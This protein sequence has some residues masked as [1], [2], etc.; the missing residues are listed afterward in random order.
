MIVPRTRE[1][2][3]GHDGTVDKKGAGADHRASARIVTLIAAGCSNE[4]VGVRLGIS[5]RTAKAHSDVLRQK[6]GVRRR[7]QI[8]IAYRLLTGEDPL[9]AERAADGR[10]TPPLI[11]CAR[12]DS[13]CRGRTDLGPAVLG[14]MRE[15]SHSGQLWQVPRQ[16]ALCSAAG[17]SSGRGSWRFS[18]NRR[19]ASGRSWLRRLREDD[20]GRAMGRYRRPPPGVVHRTPL[21]DGCRGAG[22]RVG[23]S[24]LPSSDRLRGA[25]AR[26]PSSALRLD[27]E[28]RC[29]RRDP[30]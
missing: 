16:Q 17:S 4:E 10:R 24:R 22:T 3:H 20:S 15:S 2:G 27:C 7:R 18:T 29:S 25:P 23:A 1:Y 21:V 30:C 14:S 8:P 5:P 28:G 9:A 11:G 13:G 12:G 19:L 26:A 6:L